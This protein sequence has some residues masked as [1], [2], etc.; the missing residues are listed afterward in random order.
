ME[1]AGGG[2]ALSAS[3]SL[4]FVFSLAMDDPHPRVSHGRG[5]TNPVIEGRHVRLI[6]RGR[7]ESGERG[8]QR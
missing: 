5:R 7:R 6:E 8:L 2:N 1:N 3:F 4:G